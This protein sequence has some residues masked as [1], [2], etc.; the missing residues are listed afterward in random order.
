MVPTRSAQ[1]C[2]LGGAS[3][4]Q[5]LHSCSQVAD[6]KTHCLQSLPAEERGLIFFL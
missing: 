1:N 4:E 6:L 5:L 2:S 3:L